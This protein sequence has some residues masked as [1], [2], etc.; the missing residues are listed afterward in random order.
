[1]RMTTKL[2]VTCG[3]L[4]IAA[5]AG[6]GIASAEPNIDALVNSTCT[7]PQVIAALQAEDPVVAREI[8]SDGVKAGFLQSLISQSPEGRRASI[9][10]FQGNPYLAQYTGTINAVAATCNN[11]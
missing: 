2:A 4:L 1:M 7:Y 9:Q 6:S 8:T 3:G 10:Q 5:G 11:Y